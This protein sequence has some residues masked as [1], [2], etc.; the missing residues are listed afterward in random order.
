[1]KALYCVL[2]ASVVM[3]LAGCGSVQKPG[4]RAGVEALSLAPWRI[5]AEADAD[6]DDHRP[7]ELHRPVLLMHSTPP[8][9]ELT[10]SPEHPNA[11]GKLDVPLGRRWKHIVIHHS[12]TES[13][14]EEIFDNYHR[15]H[16]G[17]LGVGYHFVIGNGYGSDDGAIEVT[18]RWEKQL[19]GAHA[20]VREYNEHG[21]GICLVGNFEHGHP[22]QKQMASLVALVNYLQERCHIPTSHVLLHRH[23]K[24]TACPGKNFPFYRFISLMPH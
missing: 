11:T 23:I 16:N 4:A 2:V 5:E 14:N 3:I 9:Y 8:R 19:Q 1:M 13:G 21:I 12:F 15:N 18:F 7:A 22:T 20:G 17:W 6:P 10:R 24:N